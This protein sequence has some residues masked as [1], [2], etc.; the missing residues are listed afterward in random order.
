MFYQS[1]ILREREVLVMQRSG[2]L[3]STLE[4]YLETILRL[5]EEKG[6]ARVNDIAEMLSVHKSTVTAALKRL[7]REKLVNHS[8][9]EVTTLT[10][11]GR[12]VAERVARRHEVIRDFLIDLLQ[13]APKSAEENACRMEHVMD[14]EVFERLALFARFVTECPRTGADWLGQFQSYFQCGGRPQKSQARL[15]EWLDDMKKKVHRGE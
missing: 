11:Q 1:N 5:I 7:S 14:K 10:P 8:P 12:Q 9:Y 15:E 3:S 2:A 6:E 4:D 13:V